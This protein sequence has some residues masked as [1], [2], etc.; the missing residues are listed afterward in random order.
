MSPQPD[1]DTH[2]GAD[3]DKDHKKYIIDLRGEGSPEN[4]YNFLYKVQASKLLIKLDKISI[5]IKDPQRQSLKIET[6]ISLVV[7]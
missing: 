3:K 7:I 4:I 6:T 1:A 5:G 2:S